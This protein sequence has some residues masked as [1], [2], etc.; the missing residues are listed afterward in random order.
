M[1]LGR[2]PVDSETGGEQ[3]PAAVAHRP[4]ETGEVY[5]GAGGPL[6]LVPRKSPH[7]KYLLFVGPHGRRTRE[8]I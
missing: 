2:L 1:V 6:V 4:E 3:F 5:I 7:K 8:A